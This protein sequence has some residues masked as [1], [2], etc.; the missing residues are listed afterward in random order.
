MLRS[1]SIQSIVKALKQVL[2]LLVILVS[3]Q[4][5]AQSDMLSSQYMNSQLLINPAYA[6]VRNSFSVNILSRQQWM[7][8]KDAPTTYAVNVHS[9]LN[10]RMASIG[11]SLINYQS[12]PLQHN[13][14]TAVYSY[15]IRINHNMFLSMGLSAKL[16]H[17]NIGLSSLDV[18][19]DNDPSFAQN[20]ENGLKPNFGTGVF[21]YSPQFYFGVSMPQVLNNELSNEETGGATYIQ[22][23]SIY[24][25]SG[26]AFGLNK[27]VFF[28]PSFLARIRSEA[29]H[30]FDI[31]L[32]MLY[33]NL[34]WIG[35]SYRTNST[36][37][38]L[39]NIQVS[40]SLGFCYSY[41]FSIG[42][43]TNFGVGS[44]EVSLIIDSN[45]FIKRNRDRRFNRKKVTKKQEDK[46]VQSIR[47]F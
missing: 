19:E 9:P 28:K 36:M 11:G 35:A 25:A 43:R 18:I 39:F 15:L 7:G 44:H 1:K 33:K 20:L 31:N 23:R 12:G 21:L 29:S 40:R 4:L 13:E 17:Y 26:Y 30:V 41:D 46:A 16:N 8:I 22:Y 37:A 5:A 32:Q 14:V 10:K 27:N 45:S 34:F 47:Y 42:E 24:L 6:G 3:T 38:A 2:C